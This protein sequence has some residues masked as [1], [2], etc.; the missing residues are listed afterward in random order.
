MQSFRLNYPTDIPWKRICVTSGMIDPVVCDERLPSKWQTSLAVFKY[1]PEDEFQT[2][3]DYKITFLKITAT[4]TGY[5]P[6]DKEIQGKIN[7]NGVNVAT[8]PGLTDLLN[9]YHPC[10]GAILQVVVGPERG[11]K[12]PL[13]DY[14]FFM[15]FQ[16]KKRELYETAT[17]TQEKQ[18]RSIETLNINKS[19]GSIQS[20]EILDVDMGG[21]GFGM[22][23]TY[24]GTGG[25]FSY[26]APSG[27]WGTKRMNT[28][29]SMTQRNS[30]VGQEKRE[31]FSFT[32]HISQLYHLLD[33][34]HLGTNRVVFF[35][36]P[37]PHTLEE[38]SGF[39]R[40]PRPIDGIQE[41]FMVVAQPKD[42]DDF[43]VSLRL[44]TSHL[45][46][47]P[48]MDFHR[49]SD[50]TLVA[51]VSAS[52]ATKNDPRDGNTYMRACFITCWDVTYWCYRN[53]RSASQDYEAADDYQIESY[54][55][56]FP[57]EYRHGSGS[58]TITPNRKS[59][60]VSVRAWGRKCFKKSGVCID[61]PSSKNAYSG[62][63]RRQVQVNL[64][65]TTPIVQVGED[66]ALMITTRGLCCCA[67]GPLI[68]MEDEKI[69]S[70]ML[71][72]R[73]FFIPGGTNVDTTGSS[74][75]SPTKDEISKTDKNSDDEACTEC[76][77]KDNRYN[78]KW[79][80]KLT[81]HQANTLSDFI[82]TETLKSL[83]NPLLKLEKFVD[84]DFF[85]KQLEYSLVRSIEGRQLLNESIINDVPKD[86]IPK[87]EKYFDQSCEKITRRDL[88]TIQREDIANITGMKL[89]DVKKI[90]LSILGV[91]F[92]KTESKNKQGSKN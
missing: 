57:P 86:A 49:Y 3:P 42:Q 38:P 26:T 92:N 10:H 68:K 4:I 73:W 5:Q 33:S 79:E 18:S 27:Q 87:L 43:C 61:C 84:T 58:V 45:T 23:S 2:F 82:R 72:P 77:E 15:D 31:G 46:T 63:A 80:N 34:Y 13:S 19:V 89:E 12:I 83:N 48:I 40:G 32:T 60:T 36:Q 88:L 22:Q 71:I 81:I 28:E 7:W 47:T 29:E 55:D 21:A 20:N 70:V 11:Q 78:P 85:A 69:V 64:V 51:S 41:F 17:D 67:S 50:N 24:A 44:D 37:R 90:K 65:S 8:I 91:K 56:L 39:V 53:E 52:T 16:P 1:V 59:L 76:S 6:L 30:E 62:S 54:N 75:K 66:Q 35:L 25:G 14:P 74:D 9:S